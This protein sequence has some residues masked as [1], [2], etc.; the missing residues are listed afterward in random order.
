MKNK[1]LSLFILTTLLCSCSVQKRRYMKGFYS[2]RNNHA[3]AISYPKNIPIQIT[4]TKRQKESFTKSAMQNMIVLNKDSVNFSSSTTIKTDPVTKIGIKKN[5]ELIQQVL[6]NKSRKTTPGSYTNRFYA[7]AHKSSESL[8]LKIVFTILTVLGFILLSLL[9]A[10]FYAAATLFSA[11]IS[12]GAT[13]SF[14]G[15]EIVLIALL[16]IILTEIY[17]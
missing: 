10:V 17:N 6:K 8:F 15:V 5:A 9:V 1:I 12:A 2:E 11:P 14:I 3:K 7:N 16:I 13:A 4:T